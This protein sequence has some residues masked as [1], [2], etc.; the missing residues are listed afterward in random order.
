MRRKPRC[1]S[2]PSG[3]KATYSRRNTSLPIPRGMK[4]SEVRRSSRNYTKSFA[5]VDGLAFLGQD[6]LDRTILGRTNFVLHFH[7]FDNEQALA[8]FDMVSF[9]DKK[10]HHF[11][12]HGRKNLLSAFGF[13]GA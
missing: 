8:G 6:A 11:A 13:D 3:T 5:G 9:F 4:S 1:R 7:G 10:T 12:G 2:D